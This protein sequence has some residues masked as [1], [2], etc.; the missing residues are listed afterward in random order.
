MQARSQND[1]EIVTLEKLV[2]QH[3]NA[4]NSQSRFSQASNNIG[5]FSWVSNNTIQQMLD[6]TVGMFTHASMCHLTNVGEQ[7]WN[8]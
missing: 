2:F 8:V 7:C 3:N 6:Q 4:N 1:S 5:T